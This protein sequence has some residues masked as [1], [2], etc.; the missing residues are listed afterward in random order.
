MANL[1]IDLCAL[2]C[3]C[4]WLAPWQLGGGDCPACEVKAHYDLA[5]TRN[6]LK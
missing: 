2:D 1:N 5:K 4:P 3:E 6:R